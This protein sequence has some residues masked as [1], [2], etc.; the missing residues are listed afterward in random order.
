MK[1]EFRI[2]T[3]EDVE[4]IILLCNECFN[5]NTSLDYAKKLSIFYYKSVF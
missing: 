2:A 5:E 4:D 3:Y 1:V